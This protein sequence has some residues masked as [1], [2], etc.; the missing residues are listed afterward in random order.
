LFKHFISFRLRVI[1]KCNLNKKPHTEGK[2][3]VGNS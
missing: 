1:H 2:F 3:H